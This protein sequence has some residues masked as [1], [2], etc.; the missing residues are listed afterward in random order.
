MNFY[1]NMV[2]NHMP[3]NVRDWITYTFPSY[4][5]DVENHLILACHMHGDKYIHPT[6]YNACNYLSILGLKF[7]NVRK[8]GPRK[9]LWLVM[10]SSAIYFA[11][12]IY[13]YTLIPLDYN[14]PGDKQA[15]N[16]D[17]V[18]KWKHFPRYWPFVSGIHRSPVD[19]P[20][21][22]QWRGA[23]MFFLEL[24]LNERLGKQSRRRWFETPSRSLLRHCNALAGV[25][26]F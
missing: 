21:K 12:Y 13:I 11:L 5:V 8:R 9:S 23:L 20:H 6:L 17:D 10:L 25:S 2:S 4:T 16:Q 18:I 24:H 14:A 7:T 3:N 26:G 19:S 15:W 1:P 22:G